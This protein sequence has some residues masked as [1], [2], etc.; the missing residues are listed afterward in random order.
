MAKRSTCPV[1]LSA[2]LVSPTVP[3]YFP[4]RHGPTSDVRLR[5]RDRCTSSAL[6]GGIIRAGPG[7]LHT[8]ALPQVPVPMPMP[9]YCHVRQ[10]PT[11]HV[12]LRTCDR[13]IS[14]AL[15]GGII[16]AGP[17]SPHTRALHRVSHAHGFWVL[18]G[19]GFNI[20]VHGWAWWVLFPSG[21]R[22]A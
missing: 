9:P 8:R 20:I 16:R 10:G 7:S 2:L 21:Y 19:H 18:G 15:I 11:S 12:R 3:P 13:C 22:W 1:H 6:I 17:G 4:V 14:S 5:T